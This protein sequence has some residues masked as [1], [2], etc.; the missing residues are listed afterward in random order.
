MKYFK[1]HGVLHVLNCLYG[2]Y[3]H[4]SLARYFLARVSVAKVARLCCIFLTNQNLASFLARLL[5]ML[6]QLVRSHVSC[7]HLQVLG[8]TCTTLHVRFAWV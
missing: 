1:G 4:I 2:T 5:K 3:V 7:N 8:Q 6:L